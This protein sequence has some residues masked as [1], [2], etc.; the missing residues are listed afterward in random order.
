MSIPDS[1][2]KRKWVR[3]HTTMVSIRLNHNTDKDIIEKLEDVPSRAG[4]VKEVIRADIAK[5]QNMKK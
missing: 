2:S 1:E 4:Y 3:E 5:T